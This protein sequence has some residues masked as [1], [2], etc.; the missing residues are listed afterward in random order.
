MNSDSGFRCTGYII[1]ELP[2]FPVSE[3]KSFSN[4]NF[5]DCSSC[6][7]YHGKNYNANHLV[8][9]IHPYGLKDCPD[10]KQSKV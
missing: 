5:P 10:F 1:G 4:K 8:C 9:G 6:V 3:K 7:N 2:L